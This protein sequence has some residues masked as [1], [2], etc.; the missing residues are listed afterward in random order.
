MIPKLNNTFWSSRKGLLLQL[1]FVLIPP[2][3]FVN[4][5]MLLLFGLSISIF[6][7]WLCLRLQ[8]LKFSNVGLKRPINI[9]NT[10]LIAILSTIVLIPITFILRRLITAIIHQPANLNAF[11]SLEGHPLAFLLG[12]CVVWIFGAFGEEIFF[13]GFLLNTIYKLLPSRYFSIPV[14]WGISLVITSFLVGFG[15]TYQGI[16][17]MILTCIIGF[18]FGLIYLKSKNNLWVNIL[19]HGFYDTVAFAF[20]F[21][22]L[23]LDKI[24]KL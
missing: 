2:A 22:G 23:H 15:H 5:E 19:T 13:R 12:L 18:Y 21:V 14:K 11:K 1:V 9:G 10:C 8:K 16:T 20:V 17:G 7:C 3:I 24:L 6:I 4:S